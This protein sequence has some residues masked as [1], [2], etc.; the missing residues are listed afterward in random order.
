M[1]VLLEDPVLIL[2]TLR[3]QPQHSQLY[4][5][6]VRDFV[7]YESKSFFTRQRGR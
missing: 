4:M 3:G 5:V 1:V 6:L 2:G 7:I